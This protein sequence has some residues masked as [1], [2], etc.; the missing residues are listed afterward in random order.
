[1]GSSDEL[2]SETFAVRCLQRAACL[3]SLRR[4]GRSPRSY[5]PNQLDNV[6]LYGEYKLRPR[7]AISDR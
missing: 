7:V 5:Q 3:L 6:V 4:P 2:I 1:M